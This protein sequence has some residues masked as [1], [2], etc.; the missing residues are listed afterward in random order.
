MSIP[1]A[2]ELRGSSSRAHPLPLVK[3]PPYGGRETSRSEVFPGSG[4]TT[5]RSY[6]FPGRPKANTRRISLVSGRRFEMP[7]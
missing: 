1:R 2:R 6:F 7:S 3:L 5:G 4:I